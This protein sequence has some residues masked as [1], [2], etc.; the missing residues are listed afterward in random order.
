[1]TAVVSSGVGGW[2]FTFRTAGHSEYVR[3]TIH[4]ANKN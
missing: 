3:I 2:K 4:G 1:M